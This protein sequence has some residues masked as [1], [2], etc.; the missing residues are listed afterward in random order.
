MNRLAKASSPYLLQHANNPVDWYEWG[1]EALQKAKNEDKPLLI[2]IGYSACHWCHVMERESFTDKEVAEYMNA[3]FVCVKVDREERPDLDQI[4]IDA[5]QLLNG[6]AGWPLNAFA[7][8]D[9][10]PFWIGV[11]FPRDQWLNALTQLHHAYT[12]NRG[13]VEE[14]AENLT[15]GVNEE[16]LLKTDL[17]TV[18]SFSK[19]DYNSLWE[20]WMPRIDTVNGG[21]ASKQKF[22]M[23]QGWQFLLQYA[24]LTRNQE[25]L[26]RVEQ[27]LKAMAYG[28]IYDQLRGGFARYATDREWF[29]PHFEKMLYDNAQ[30]IS[31]YAQAYAKTKDLLY[32]EVVKESLRFVKEELTSKE[33]AFFS[34]L[35][36]DSE[37]EEGKFYVWSSEEIDTVLEPEQAHIFK[38]YYHI[39]PEG[40]WEFGQNIL[41][42]SRTPEE[43]AKL[44]DLTP[45]RIEF[46][47]SAAKGKLLKVRNRRVRPSRDEKI[48]T[49]WNALMIKAYVDA[50][51]ALGEDWYLNAAILNARFLLQKLKKEDGGFYRNYK[52]GKTSIPGF[53]DDYAY[54]A[55]AFVALYQV[56]YELNWLTEA[57]RIVEY[58]LANFYDKKSGLFY[59]TAHHAETLIARKIQYMD[60]EMPSA[61]A[62]MAQALFDVGTYF[63]E[64]TY[65]DVAQTMLSRVKTL[66]KK[67]A[68]YFGKWAQFLGNLSYTPHEIAIMGKEAISKSREMQREYIPNAY[69]MGGQK[70]DL[71]MLKGKRI[72]GK[73][74]IYVCQNKTCQQPVDEVEKALKQLN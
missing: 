8:P 13:V 62:S 45:S 14:Q 15:H 30:L 22:P 34:A 9:G 32:L 24:Q 68:P 56:T 17:E 59:Y 10:K 11:Y 63:E 3:H 73:T 46:M 72:E 74:M 7:L 29:A 37:G 54:L 71:P 44:I 55:E 36:A 39:I 38:A 67:G 57:K 49:S 69:Y 33:G 42:R 2:S 12:S 43:L 52:D 26:K 66:L 28:G 1:E 19:V 35:N 4:Y 25:V 58:V 5:A 21:F 16:R 60:N 18:P 70:E 40:N 47:V 65:L 23:A 6:N 27:S 53:L 50:Y 64:S 41:F 31:L 48:L 20:E 51:R 61:N